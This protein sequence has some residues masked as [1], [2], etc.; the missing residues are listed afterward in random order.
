[1]E[2]RNVVFVWFLGAS[3]LIM[4]QGQA[5]AMMYQSRIGYLK[6]AVRNSSFGQLQ[7]QDALTD[8]ITKL[9]SFAELNVTEHEDET[10]PTMSFPK[11]GV[12]D[13]DI[14]TDKRSKRFAY[15]GTH[16]TIKHLT[17][18]ISKYPSRLSKS[19]TDSELLKAFSVWSAVSPLT[20]T[21]KRSVPVNIEI[22]FVRQW[23]G[24]GNPFDGPGGVLAHAT[25]PSNNVSY[26]HFDKAEHWTIN[27]HK[28]VNLFQVAA[29]EFGHVLG[30]SHS[31][32]RSA[33]MSTDY[34]GYR[35]DFQLDNDDIF[36]IQALYGKRSKNT[37]ITP[38]LLF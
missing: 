31:D 4:A 28:G 13:K 20:F 30:L 7:F 27:G 2:I 19:E 15:Q 36:A 37:L 16:W 5:K 17:Y 24:D 26:V 9:Q 11:C 33:L 10:Q 35:P 23:H 3:C 12:K 34:C 14:P 32:K 38:H 21:Q 29:H 18:M 8:T 25:P 1:M 6:Q 22:R